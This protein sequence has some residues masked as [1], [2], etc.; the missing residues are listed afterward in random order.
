ME[1]ILE[2]MK[3]KKLTYEEYENLLIE[4]NPI[5]AYIVHMTDISQSETEKQKYY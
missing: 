3:E 1:N 4:Y 5:Y 2:K